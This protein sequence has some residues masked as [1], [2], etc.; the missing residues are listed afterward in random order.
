MLAAVC[1]DRKFECAVTVAP[2]P[3]GLRNAINEAKSLTSAEASTALDAKK[4]QLDELQATVT[5]AVRY[6]PMY[7]VQ[8]CQATIKELEAAIE[9]ARKAASTRKKFTFSRKTGPSILAGGATSGSNDTSVTSTG[10]AAAVADHAPAVVAAPSAPAPAIT[11]ASSG[12]AHAESWQRFQETEREFKNETGKLLVLHSGEAKHQDGV[13]PEFRLTNLTD[14][15]V[16]LYV[17]PRPNLCRRA[18]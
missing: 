14:C 2:P 8:Q 3:T 17:P 4:R 18:S 12:A 9:A 13:F 16:I 1:E 5:A 10:A 6:L 11:T 15:T 7:D